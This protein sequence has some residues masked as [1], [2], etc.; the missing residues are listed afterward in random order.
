MIRYFIIL[1]LSLVTHKNRQNSLNVLRNKS[2]FLIEESAKNWQVENAISGAVSVLF[3]FDKTGNF[4]FVMSIARL[5]PFEFTWMIFL[6][7]Y[8]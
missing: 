6:K 2:I 4:L 1:D 3:E 7:A 8:R 5:R